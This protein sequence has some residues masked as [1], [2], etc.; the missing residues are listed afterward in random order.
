[1]VAVGE[2]TKP[3]VR[4]EEEGLHEQLPSRVTKLGTGLAEV[5]VKNLEAAD[6]G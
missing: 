3:S 1:M 5:K 2:K 6:G 4:Q